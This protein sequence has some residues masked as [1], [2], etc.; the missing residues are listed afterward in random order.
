MFPDLFIVRR[1]EQGYQFDILEPHDPSL[2]DNA[3]KAK[4]LA[5]FA[6]KHWRHFSRIQLV[7]KKK[8]PDGQE[9]FY[10]LDV[11][12]DAIRKQVLAV[13]SDQHLNQIFEKNAKLQQ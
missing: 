4:G 2:N 1:D 11:G 5:A 6:E 3:A 8:A 7:R 13:E 12:V 10:R 9:R